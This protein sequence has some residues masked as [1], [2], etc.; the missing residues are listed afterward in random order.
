MFDLRAFGA[1]HGGRFF[2]FGSA[3]KDKMDFD[4][5]LDV[6][7]D[8]PIDDEIEA[9]DFVESACRKRD[10]PADVH[11]RSKSGDRFI[12]AVRKEAIHLP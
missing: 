9:I 6:V 2:L 1:A 10:L 8:F 12:E 5:D 7:I 3:A 4:S 11:V